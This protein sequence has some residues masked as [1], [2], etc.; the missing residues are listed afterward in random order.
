MLLN[1]LQT[2]IVIYFIIEQ[3]RKKEHRRK[4]PGG[5]VVKT[6]SNARGTDSIPGWGTKIPYGAQPKN[7]NEQNNNKN[8]KISFKKKK[9][10]ERGPKLWQS[11]GEA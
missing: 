5:P 4:F 3:E 7:K 9:R 11:S 1:N 6:A 10:G 2:N 8:N